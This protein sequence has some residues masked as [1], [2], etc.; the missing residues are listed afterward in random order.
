G[1]LQLQITLDQLL[2]PLV[3]RLSQHRQ[4]QRPGRAIDQLHAEPF[5]Q[6]MNDLTD[7]RLRQRRLLGGGR[8][9]ETATTSDVAKH[10]ER[11]KLHGLIL[12][13]FSLISR[14][15]VI[16]SPN[17]R[18]SSARRQDLPGPQDRSKTN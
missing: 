4:L 2:A 10:L 12:S 16:N 6:L 14:D 18:K 5:L 1:R 9:R 11:L 13:C 8:L 7:R 17:T 3:I 15:A